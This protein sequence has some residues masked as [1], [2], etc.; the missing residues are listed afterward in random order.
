MPMVTVLAYVEVL[1]ALLI[2]VFL[3][4]RKSVV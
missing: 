3:L 2:L 4:D 1:I